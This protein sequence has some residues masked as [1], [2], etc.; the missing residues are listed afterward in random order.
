MERLLKSWLSF[1]DFTFISDATFAS[2]LFLLNTQHSIKL[3]RSLN[4]MYAFIKTQQ[5]TYKQKRFTGE[6]KCNIFGLLFVITKHAIH[7]SLSVNIFLCNHKKSQR[8]VGL[9]SS[10]NMYIHSQCSREQMGR[11]ITES[12]IKLHKCRS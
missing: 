10:S 12:I 6:S 3:C 8:N 9:I 4:F 5:R 7:F 11:L 1:Q 2:P